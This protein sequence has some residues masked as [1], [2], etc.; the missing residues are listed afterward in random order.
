M[1]CPIEGDHLVALPALTPAALKRHLDGHLHGSGA[2]V[3]EEHPLQTRPQRAD[4]FRQLRGGLVT[5]IGEDHLL[6]GLGLAGN[7]RGNAGFA[8]AM[9]GHPPAADAIDQPAAILKFQPD[10]IAPLDR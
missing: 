4:A 6:E 1:I 3:G 2:V 5:E 9:Q 10:A 8:V 7:G